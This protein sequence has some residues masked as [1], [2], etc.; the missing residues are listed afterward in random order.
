MRRGVAMAVEAELHGKR[1]G[2]LSQRHLVDAAVTFDAAD[3]L[4]NVYVVTEEHIIRE[5][6]HA[7]PFQRNIAG[8]AFTHGC[9]HR[10]AGPD[11]RMAGHASVRRRQTGMRSFGDRGVAV[12]AVDA[13]LAIVMAVAKWHRLRRWMGVRP[14][15]PVGVP[16]T[17]R[18]QNAAGDE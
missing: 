7:I 15:D 1:P 10:R 3:A 5:H 6:G 9:E 18:K 11:L 16:E 8:K 2:A 12:A 4:G 13:E 17:D 14:G